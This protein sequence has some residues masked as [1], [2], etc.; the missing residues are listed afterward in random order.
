MD[1]Q[2]AFLD[3]H[4]SHIKRDGWTVIPDVIPSDRV[5]PLRKSVLKIF[6]AATYGE[7]LGVNYPNY[8]A[9]DQGLAPYLAS[10][11]VLD[12]AETVFGPGVRITSTRPVILDPNGTGDRR[13]W[14]ADWPF[15][16]ARAA[17]IPAPYPDVTIH[18]TTLFMLT[19]F[20]KENGGTWIVPGSHRSSNNP[21]GNN[22]VDS[23]KPYP[24]EMQ[25]TG[26]A[27][28]VLMFDSRLWHGHPTNYTDKHRVAVR[29][30]YAPWWLNVNP[31]EKDATEKDLIEQATGKAQT[32]QG[33]LP[34]SAY[35]KLPEE[36]KPLYRHWVR[37]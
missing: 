31:T 7:D 27:G 2:T 10:R 24:T 12:L 11:K 20:T 25:V 9:F 15:N 36:A 3:H 6:T 8:L 4:I 17:C 22:G 21:T 34:K 33:T 29:A 16:Q 18:L 32:T 35:E 37:D 13:S 28:S 14:H 5:G 30:N 19:D 26:K 1:T 23:K